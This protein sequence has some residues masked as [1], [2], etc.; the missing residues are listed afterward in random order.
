MDSDETHGLTAHQIETIKTILAPFA[1]QIERIGL[2]GSRA[3]NQHH[4]Y[5][6]I[7]LVFYGSIDQ[8]TA[9]RIWT[10]FNESSLPMKVDVAVYDLI[11]NPDLKAH[12]D[13]VSLLFLTRETI[14]EE[15]PKIKGGMSQ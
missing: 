6:D 12:I 7:D 14:V 1:A 10:L 4:P 5:S 15:R 9:D 11:K 3:Q 2:F 8:K 13:R